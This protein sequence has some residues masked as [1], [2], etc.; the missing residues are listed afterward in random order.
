MCAQAVIVECVAHFK[1]TVSL[2]PEIRARMRIFHP[3][4]VTTYHTSLKA[5]GRSYEQ[6]AFIPPAAGQSK[7]PWMS[8]R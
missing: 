4:E 3:A 1:C 2:S 7:W 8:T 6:P 5:A